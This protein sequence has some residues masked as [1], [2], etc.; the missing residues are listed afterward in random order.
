MSNWLSYVLPVLCRELTTNDFEHDTITLVLAPSSAM[1]YGSTTRINSSEASLTVPLKDRVPLLDLSF[2]GSPLTLT[3][4]GMLSGK[5]VL[6][7]CKQP[8]S[9]KDAELCVLLCLCLQVT[10]SV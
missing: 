6:S 7:A 8:P 2:T 5:G 4:A 10:K 9:K 1:P 3:Q